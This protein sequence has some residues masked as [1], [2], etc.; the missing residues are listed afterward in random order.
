MKKIFLFILIAIYANA[1]P[2]YLE[3]LANMNDQNEVSFTLSIDAEKSQVV[4]KDKERM[5]TVNGIFSIDTINFK[6]TK[7][8]S[9]GTIIAII[10]Y[11]LNRETLKLKSGVS[12]P[13]IGDSLNSATLYDHGYCRIFEKPKNNKI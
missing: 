13:S 11:E 8:F 10:F 7:R 3:C 12:F 5:E 9:D 1:E 4:Y 6:H 2:V